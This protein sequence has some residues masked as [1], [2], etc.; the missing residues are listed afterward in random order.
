MCA[1]CLPTSTNEEKAQALNAQF[2]SVFT[3]S[4]ASSMLPDKGASPYE[5]IQNLHISPP[6]V[7][8]QLKELNIN[9]ASGPDEI[10]ARM[11]RDYADE[12]TPALTHLFQQSYV[13]G[14]L[15]SDWSKARVA[16]IYKSGDKSNPANYRPVS[17]TCLCCNILKHI[18]LS[19]MSKFLENK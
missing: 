18:I 10:P 9:K 11:L 5:P 1:K 13:K 12:I 6:G 15:P 19:H 7:N 3:S 16:S 2:S 14:V 17:L 4:D 8:K